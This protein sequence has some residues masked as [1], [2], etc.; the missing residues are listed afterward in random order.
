MDKKHS[1]HTKD[2]TFEHYIGEAKLDPI[3][4]S[5]VVHL[6]GGGL[7]RW[8][9]PNVISHTESDVDDE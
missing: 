4:N 3:E 7:I 5:L 9:W 2:G 6:A 1:V 8:Y